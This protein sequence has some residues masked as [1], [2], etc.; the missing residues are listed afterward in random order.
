MTAT[1]YSALGI[2]YSRELRA[3]GYDEVTMQLLQAHNRELKEHQAH[4][5]NWGW[6]ITDTGIASKTSKG[7]LETTTR[8]GWTF[9]QWTRT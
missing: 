1:T 9:H 6:V 5:D 8:A 4:A 2:P 7:I 3:V